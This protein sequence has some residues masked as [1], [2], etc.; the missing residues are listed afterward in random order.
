MPPRLERFVSTESFARYGGS[1]SEYDGN[2]SVSSLS[3]CSLTMREAAN[4]KFA[5]KKN[6]NESNVV[7]G[8]GG[9]KTT[10]RQAANS[11]AAKPATNK[12]AGPA[13][14][15][16]GPRTMRQA[17]CARHLEKTRSKSSSSLIV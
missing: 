7:G 4:Y 12:R 13:K 11:K 8:G 1:E 5:Y 17:V 15:L 3:R 9:P 16:T 2:S 6:D 10:M 14:K